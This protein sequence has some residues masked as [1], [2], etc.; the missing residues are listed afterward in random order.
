[1]FKKL[2]DKTKISNETETETKCKNITYNEDG[3]EFFVKL[4]NSR[5]LKTGKVEETFSKS[6]Y[7]NNIKK[8][9]IGKSVNKSEWHTE[10]RL[11]EKLIFTSK[12]GY[13]TFNYY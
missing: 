10:L 7:S 1:M 2:F 5:C 3:Q 6:D 9:L 11:N 12:K 13:G 8:E 4:C